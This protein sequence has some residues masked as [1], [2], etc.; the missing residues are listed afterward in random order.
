MLKRMHRTLQI[1]DLDVELL[2]LTHWHV[3]AVIA[4]HY[5]SSEGRIFLVGDAA[6]RVPPWGALG[7]NSGI[8]DADNLVWKLALS[9]KNPGLPLDSLLDTYDSERRPIGERIAR[10]S[11]ES[12][13][14]HA[15]ILDMALGIT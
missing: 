3:N 13:E 12:M 9:L 5:R 6:H 2:S 8:Q 11:L 4:E 15:L 7:M 1:P 14:A 10:T